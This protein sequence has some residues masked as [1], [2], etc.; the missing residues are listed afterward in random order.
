MKEVVAAIIANDGRVLIAR[1]DANQNLAGK[2]EFPG[3]KLEPGE[4]PKQCLE[5][6]IKEELGIVIA[7]DGF[8]GKTQWNRRAPRGRV[9]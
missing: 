4:T 2:W 3:G 1:R 5:R 6:E 9:S 8:L 7:V